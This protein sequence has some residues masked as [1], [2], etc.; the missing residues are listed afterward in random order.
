MYVYESLDRFCYPKL[1]FHCA[2]YVQ[3][4]YVISQESTGKS[5]GTG[6]SPP[7]PGSQVPTIGLAFSCSCLRLSVFYQCCEPVNIVVHS[8]IRSSFSHFSDNL[9]QLAGVLSLIFYR[10][11]IPDIIASVSRHHYIS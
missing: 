2:C 4:S 1:P 6:A 10:E 9:Y 8:R 5:E 3:A 7:Q 11:I